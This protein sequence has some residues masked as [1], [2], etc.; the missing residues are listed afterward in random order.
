MLPGGLLYQRQC[1]PQAGGAGEQDA[2]LT[3]ALEWLRAVFNTMLREEMKRRQA[4]QTEPTDG[5]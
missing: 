5:E 1:W 2:R 4:A 3:E